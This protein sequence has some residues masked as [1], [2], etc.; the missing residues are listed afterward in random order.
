MRDGRF[1]ADLTGTARNLGG[2]KG[3]TGE[4]TLEL[5]GRFIAR[6]VVIATVSGDRR[7]CASAASVI[8]RCKIA[9][10]GLRAARDPLR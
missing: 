4:F 1:S 8:S 9:E 2:V 7:R 5:T 6:D 3:R 10:A